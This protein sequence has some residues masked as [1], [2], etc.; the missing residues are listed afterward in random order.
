MDL[1][2]VGVRRSR[3]TYRGEGR[4]A[5]SLLLRP[6]PCL[7]FLPF[8]ASVLVPGTDL[9]QVPPRLLQCRA[10]ECLGAGCTGAVTFPRAA[11]GPCPASF[12]LLSHYH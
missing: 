1:F 11:L 8:L 3:H 6:H 10:G 12:V 2:G 7:L 4:A 9:R 5:Y